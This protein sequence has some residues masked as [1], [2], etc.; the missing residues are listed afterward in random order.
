MLHLR[1]TGFAPLTLT[2]PNAL[3]FT[4]AWDPRLGL[5]TLGLAAAVDYEAFAAAHLLPQLSFSLR[6]VFA[7]GS[8]QSPGTAYHVTVLDEDDAR[9]SHLRFASGGSVVAGAIGSVIGTL[10]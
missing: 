1:A 2:G 3:N 7:D 4:A 10:S 5:A 6:F 9:P 8:R